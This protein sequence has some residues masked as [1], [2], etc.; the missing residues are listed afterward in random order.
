MM[1]SNNAHKNYKKESPFKNAP[2]RLF[3]D[4]IGFSISHELAVFKSNTI[5]YKRL[6]APL[7]ISIL[8]FSRIVEISGE[9][10]KNVFEKL[11]S[12]LKPGLPAPPQPRA[13]QER[14]FKKNKYQ[15]YP[16]RLFFDRLHLTT[17]QELAVFK[18]YP[19]LYR[20]IQNPDNLTIAE[21]IIIAELSNSNPGQLMAELLTQLKLFT[22]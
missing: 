17:S 1:E 4:A 5:L 11:L 13:D 14:V 2:L 15:E 16:L 20:R 3:F 6:R 10:S 19:A 21:I 18:N 22:K 12:F 7:D 9:P 8:E